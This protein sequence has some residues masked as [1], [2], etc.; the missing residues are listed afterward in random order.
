MY[1]P[2]YHA[3]HGRDAMH[4]LI[5]AHPLGAWVCQGFDGLEANHLP[6]VL[7][8]NRGPHGT[9][10]GHV[11]RGNPVWQQLASGAPSVVM[12]M[13]PQAYISPNWYPGKTAH[14]KVVPTWNYLAVH[15]HG[16]ARAVEDRDWMLDMLRRLTHANEAAQPQP[17]RVEDAP[18]DF[19]D[20]LLGAIV[21]IEILI[22]RLE[23]RNKASQ[24]EDLQDR[25]G[26]V[27]GL[28]AS[29]GEQAAAVAAGVDAA[30]RAQD[31]EQN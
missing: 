27:Q 1:L 11:A 20:K 23:G 24:D 29:G 25:H 6:W 14:G 8:R 22:D 26:T 18:A 21:G 31:V 10:I 19:I 4:D 2:P 9:L 16:T 12:F 7:D 5:D 17:W 3:L 15:A 30:I 28:R 13:G